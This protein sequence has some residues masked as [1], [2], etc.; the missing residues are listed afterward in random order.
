[1]HFSGYACSGLDKG[2][3]YDGKAVVVGR[4]YLY[5][6]SANVTGKSEHNEELCFRMTGPVVHQL[7]VRLALHKHKGVLWTTD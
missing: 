5:T 1:M 6:G 3:A 2:G 7:L 4:R